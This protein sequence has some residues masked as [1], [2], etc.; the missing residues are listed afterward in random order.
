MNKLQFL[1]KIGIVFLSTAML[2]ISSCDII[3]P[4]LNPQGTECLLIKTTYSIPDGTASTNTGF[5]YDSSDK[6]VEVKRIQGDLSSD[7]F[8]ERWEISYSND[9]VD[10]IRSFTKF[11]SDPEED[12]EDY[13]FF[14]KG[15]LPDSIAYVREGVYN[16]TGYLIATY[17]ND[18]LTRLV[19]YRYKPLDSTYFVYNTS[20]LEWSGNNL[21]KITSLN[22]NGEQTTE[23][24]EYDN[25]KSPLSCL[26]L[27]FSSYGSLVMLSSN[28]VTQSKKTIWDGTLRT[29]SFVYTYLSS[30]YP[31]SCKPSNDN[32]TNFQY[33]CN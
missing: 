8:I 18:Q 22:V 28:N 19:D 25:K 10:R 21:K 3:D 15:N 17:T 23:E 6:L 26:G 30:D 31:K 11:Q 5:E 2:S 29:T 20:N 1:N 14:Y 24:L 7:T 16:L 4:F 27:A 33:R 9:Q 13:R 32:A 12:N